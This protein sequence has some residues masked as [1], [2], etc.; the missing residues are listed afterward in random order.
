MDRRIAETIQFGGK[1][2]N[3]GLK[4][5][6]TQSI[7]HKP[8]NGKSKQIISNTR[9]KLDPFINTK[10]DM[11]RQSKLAIVSKKKHSELCIDYDSDSS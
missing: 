11:F 5:K 9:L 4:Q 8:I 6:M 1:N 3:E 2:N 10:V 7:F